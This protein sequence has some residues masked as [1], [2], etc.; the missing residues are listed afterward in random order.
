MEFN[1]KSTS[2][3]GKILDGIFEPKPAA[4][5]GHRIG[6]QIRRGLAVLLSA[7]MI[8]VPMGQEAFAQSALYPQQGVPPEYSDQTPPPDQ[9]VPQGQP[10]SADQLDQLVA[11]IALY[12]DALVAQLLVAA[13][14]PTQVVEADRWRQSQGNAPADQIAAGADTHNWDPSVKALTAFPT[15]LAQMDRNLQWTT[16]LGNAYY[17]QPQDIM[18]SV[19]AMRQKAEAAGQ[20]RNTPQQ[21]VTNEGGAIAIAPANPTVVYVPVYDPW[22]VYGSPFPMYPGYYYAPPPGI[23]FGGLAIGFGVGVGIGV[24]SHWGWGW[25]RWGMGWHDRAVYYNHNHYYTHSTTVINR[26]FYR[27]GGPGRGYGPRG[28]YVRGGYRPGG[29]Y[30]R[31]NV[32]YR[33]GYGVNRAGVGR[34]GGSYGRP[35]AIN[36]PAPGRSA[37]N[38]SR[39]NASYGRPG[40]GGV[41]R[42]SMNRGPAPVAHGGGG[43]PSGGGGGGSH[44]A[45]HGGG[46]EGHGR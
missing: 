44:G 4:L 15:V 34:P 8:M 12:P 32:G 7:L 27:P 41:P 36:R 9:E 42:A 3:A 2:P 46:H 10:L 11:P 14:Y 25:N 24:F 37:G 22:V 29:N 5:A 31:P 17:N 30:G 13:T 33:G 39:P 35:G 23:F 16:D 28:A 18:D 43:R 6:E 19:Q 38:Y 21:V 1:E 20:L 40:G 45:G 26:G